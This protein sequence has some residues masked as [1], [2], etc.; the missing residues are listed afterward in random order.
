MTVE[1]TGPEPPEG[2]QL[3]GWC[4]AMA[5]G[6]LAETNE[7]AIKAAMA[8]DAP[9][10]VLRITEIIPVAVAQTMALMPLPPAAQGLGM[11][12]QIPTVV[13]VCWG[14]MNGLTPVKSTSRLQVPGPGVRVPL[15]GRAN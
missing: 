9:R 3:C 7:A 10:L 1:W 6:R 8:P 12:P 14:C 11:P 13:N 4:A 5:K 2:Q 15:D